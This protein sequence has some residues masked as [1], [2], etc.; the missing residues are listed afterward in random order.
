M[1]AALH[2]SVLTPL[3]YWFG[4]SGF[5][6]HF[7]SGSPPQMLQYYFARL[8]TMYAYSAPVPQCTCWSVFLAARCNWCFWLWWGFKY[9]LIFSVKQIYSVFCFCCCLSTNTGEFL[10]LLKISFLSLLLRDSKAS[11]DSETTTAPARSPQL[12]PLS[13]FSL[14]LP[15]PW[16]KDNTFPFLSLAPLH[17]HPFYPIHH[18]LDHT[19]PC[20]DH[21]S[22]SPP[23]CILTSR[24]FRL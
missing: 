13:P 7:S 12:A 6:E 10:V 22:L 17:S 19:L 15:Y 9:W 16:S 5:E 2:N 20:L 21:I 18:Y 23:C 4:L 14:S 3:C 1:C 24:W 8:K 11:Y